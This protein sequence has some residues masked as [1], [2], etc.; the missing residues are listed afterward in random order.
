MIADNPVLGVGANN[1]TSAM[2]QYATSEFRHEWLWAVHNKY[3]LILAETGIGG[4]LAYVAFLLS[5]LR[6]G[7][8]CWKLGDS[9]LSPLALGLVA[10]IAGHM[11]H[12]GVDLFRDRPLQQLL[13]LVAGL[14][15]AMYKIC[16]ADQR[17]IPLSS[18]V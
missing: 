2:D 15:A 9:V 14:L 10:A 17:R 3:L 12:Q 8:Q 6:K 16:A 13:L 1:F 7:W 4:L 11:V 18:T 5:I